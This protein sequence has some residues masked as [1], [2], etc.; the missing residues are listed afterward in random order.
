MECDQCQVLGINGVACHETGC[1]NAWLHPIS[2]EPYSQACAECGCDYKP[3]EMLQRVCSDCQE[4][5]S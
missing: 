1:P 2:G 5:F 3:E 4:D